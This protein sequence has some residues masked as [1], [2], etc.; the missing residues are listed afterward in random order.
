[1]IRKVF[2]FRDFRPYQGEIVENILRGR[3]V[4]A[5]MPTGG[6]KSLCY[7]LPSKML[8]GTVVVISPLISLMKDQVDAAAQ[9]GLR[10]AFM[11]SSLTGPEAADIRRMLAAGRLEM[12]YI[13]PE[14]FARP[15]FL[16]LLKGIP[17]SLFAVD[18]AHCI[19]EWGHDFRPD[20]LSLSGIKRSFPGVAVAAFTATA[21]FKV[22]ADIIERLGLNN[23]FV[24]RA[25]FDRPNLFYYV[26][27]KADPG[28]QVVEFLRQRPGQCGIV[29]RAT[30]SSVVEL[31]QFL[32]SC[33][34]RALPYHA[35]LDE[36]TRR[37]NQE[38]F[39]RDEADVIVATVAFGMGIDKS[40]VRFVIHADL[41]KNIESYYQETGRA[42][43]DGEAAHCLL[44]FGRGDIPKIR[45]FIDKI[46]GDKERSVALGK[47]SQVVRYAERNRCRRRSLLEYFGERYAKENCRACD[48][49]SGSAEKVEATEDARAVI[50]AIM[51]AGQRFGI[52]YTLDIICGARTKR[53]LRL[54]HDNL[55]AYGAGRHKDK[56]YWS[57]LLDEL[58]AQEIIYQDDG[59]YP[60]LRLSRAAGDV[61]NGRRKVVVLK[62]EEAK[63]KAVAGDAGDFDLRLFAKLRAIRKG[64]A[65]RENVPPFVIF[66][67]K[68]LY[69]MCRY[70]PA[71]ER[72]MAGI[73]GVG[74]VKLGRYGNLFIRAIKEYLRD[75]P[76]A[77]KAKPLARQPGRIKQAA[78]SGSGTVDETYRLLKQGLSLKD[79]AARRKRALSTIRGHIEQLIAEKDD[80]DIDCFVEPAKR[81]KIE[82][83]FLS[84]G[85]RKLTP[86]VES[87]PGEVT[88][89]EA[90]LTRAFL[91]RE[92]SR[93]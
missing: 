18:E 70:Y 53:I 74:E 54:G 2:G 81:R 91:R 77:L 12:L 64:L 44:L 46:G 35:G 63:K 82:Q 47:L 92:E 1:M 25:S 13:A 33:G 19:S 26:E 56:R 48:I 51:Q 36:R 31:A 71:D 86:V 69:E 87:F 79:I 83:V 39:S 72:E 43:R 4:F 7:Q 37:M 30:R 80:V 57:F 28:R 14:R 68:T 21:T 41:P 34:I 22:Q 8:S 15:E 50:A 58:M 23:P 62:R 89:E 75:N 20:Y 55:K 90:G 76:G 32:R 6:G 67:D 84:L 65:D 16:Q 5:V 49:C 59:E 93:G 17:I 40:N 60:V 73:S 61:L 45:Y 42:G 11:N 3:D 9:N 24:L 38:A 66:S 10:A 85:T 27:R 88:F 52:R 78:A 29:Y